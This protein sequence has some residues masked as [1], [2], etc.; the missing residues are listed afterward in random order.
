MNLSPQTLA[1]IGFS[2]LAIG[3]LVR[4]LKSDTPLP[5][6]VPAKWRPVLA[7][8]LGLL[9]GVL[10]ALSTG[11]PWRD[12]LLGGLSAGVAAIVGHDVGIESLRGGVE[13]GAPKDPGAPALLFWIGAGILTARVVIGC[14]GA[15]EAAYGGSLL[16]CVDH[17]KTLEESHACRKA[18]DQDWHVV[19]GGAQ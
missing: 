14:A 4:L 16:Q 5:F 10:H 11:V 3:L 8:V 17:A 18:V 19:D 9:S 13:V 12:A 7:L 6:T 2:A 15:A 1:W